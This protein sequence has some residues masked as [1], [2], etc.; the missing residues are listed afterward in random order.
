MGSNPAQVASAIL[1]ATR[2]LQ[3]LAIGGITVYGVS[4]SIFNVEGGH[5]AVVFNRLMGLKETVSLA[6]MAQAW[7]EPQ[8]PCSCLHSIN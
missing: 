3:V 7:D 4:H 5:R 6:L 1:N 2:A 8:V